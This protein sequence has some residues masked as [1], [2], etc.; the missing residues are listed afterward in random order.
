MTN[1][2]FIITSFKKIIELTEVDDFEHCD[3]IH[4]K[5]NGTEP[6]QY[7]ISTEDELSKPVTFQTTSG[8]SLDQVLDVRDNQ[9][10]FIIL[11]TLDNLD[12]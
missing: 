7:C 1:T 2:D 5:V 6:F 4:V 8:N 10:R 12:Q 11:K 9:S 3:S